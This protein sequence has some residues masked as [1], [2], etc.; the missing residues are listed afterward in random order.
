M[1]NETKKQSDWVDYKV[2][3]FQHISQKKKIIVLDVLFCC[4]QF[5]IYPWI[6][7]I[8]AKKMHSPCNETTT[9]KKTKLHELFRRM[10]ETI[11][12]EHKKI[13]RKKITQNKNFH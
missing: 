11:D 2:I 7:S 9:Q 6:C 5:S 8:N 12:T 4:W 3:T 1:I 13:S 10:C